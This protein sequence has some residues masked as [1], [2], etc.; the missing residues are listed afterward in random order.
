MSTIKQH[1]VVDI[2]N[3]SFSTNPYNNFITGGV[4]ISGIGRTLIRTDGTTE[5]TN[6]LTAKNIQH[7]TVKITPID[8]DISGTGNI[9]MSTIG[10]AI[11]S[12]NNTNNITISSESIIIDSCNNTGLHIKKQPRENANIDFD[13]LLTNTGN[14]IISEHGNCSRLNAIAGNIQFEASPFNHSDFNNSQFVDKCGQIAL[15]HESIVGN[16]T[17]GFSFNLIGENSY[18][19]NGRKLYEVM[20]LSGKDRIGICGKDPER[21]L[22]VS[23]SFRVTNNDNYLNINNNGEIDISGNIDLSGNIKHLGNTDISGN[24]DISGDIEGNINNLFTIK[25]N[26]NDQQFIIN[27]IGNVGI[28]SSVATEKFEITD[29]SCALINSTNFNTNPQQ[30][31]I[32]NNL[33]F[34]HDTNP[35]YADKTINTGAKISSFMETSILDTQSGSTGM[36]FFTASGWKNPTNTLVNPNDIDLT[37]TEKMRITS[38]GNVG[39]GTTNPVVKLHVQGDIVSYIDNTNFVL[40]NSSGSTTTTNS[41]RLH[42]TTAKNAYIDYNDTTTGLHIR[43]G[44]SNVMVLSPTGNV[45]IGTSTPSEKLH[46][47]GNVITTG[48]VGIGT[49]SPGA[50]LDVV[51]SDDSGI[52][53]IRA[54]GNNQ[55]TGRVYVGQSAAYGGGITYQGDST[56]SLISGSNEDRITLFRRNNGSDSAVLSYSH[57]SNNVNIEGQIDVNGWVIAEEGFFYRRD[58]SNHNDMRI[59]H[60]YGAASGSEARITN[61]SNLHIDSATNGHTYINYYSGKNLYT[62]HINTQ[63]NSIDTGSAIVYAKGFHADGGAAFGAVKVWG[64]LG[65]HG[66]TMSQQWAG[67]GTH[68]SRSAYFEYYL[69][70]QGV[71]GR[72]DSRIKKNIKQI[73]TTEHFLNL[74]ENIQLTEYD[75]IYK[76][77]GD[78]TYGYIAQQVKNHYPDAIDLGNGFLPDEQRMIKNTLLQQYEDGEKTKWKLIIPNLKFEDNHTGMCKFYCSNNKDKE[79]K[80]IKINIESDKKTFIF[81]EKYEIIFFYGKEVND[82]H[83]IDKNKI[84]NLHHGAIQELYKEI[85][86]IKNNKPN[87]LYLL[88]ADNCLNYTDVN[89]CSI[90]INETILDNMDKKFII[91]SINKEYEINHTN[92]IF[93]IIKLNNKYYLKQKNNNF[94]LNYKHYLTNSYEIKHGMTG[95]LETY[96][97]N[98][99]FKLDFILNNNYELLLS[100]EK[101]DHIKI[102]DLIKNNFKI[103]YLCDSIP[104]IENS[105]INLINN[106]LKLYDTNKYNE[107]KKEYTILKNNY[108]HLISNAI[109]QN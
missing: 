47:I 81:D 41:L 66:T 38:T 88:I 23:G 100:N 60:W 97:N 102:D 86:K 13:E 74:I 18:G 92:E 48:N 17:W 109:L 62:R 22:D 68:K 55:G 108:E 84:Y 57:N 91:N 72:S 69:Q 53:E 95:V 6:S 89:N 9:N 35:R 58:R 52:A 87:R 30:E 76:E 25:N 29:G 73:V 63:N 103:S 93:T 27:N 67:H 15:T 26:N 5:L 8:I 70:C 16:D 106:M 107:L 19:S 20:K 46:V 99:K 78:H 80:C 56:P 79:S 32:V 75:Y 28:G 44:T 3:E 77:N 51:N 90:I 101:N 64:W 54:M 65:E 4:D 10:N 39:I 33:L 61:S 7:D 21:N 45:G 24:I 12:T 105:S 42:Y 40:G 11:F 50:S 37:L 98:N 85:K 71:M 31:T 2:S 96:N 104:C 59:G 36:S 94:N 34:K 82:F 1:I 14:I 49:T 83:Y 43:S